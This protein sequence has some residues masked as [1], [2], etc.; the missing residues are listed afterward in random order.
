M[1][2]PIKGRNQLGEVE[3]HERAAR[4][5][6]HILEAAEKRRAKKKREAEAN[7]TQRKDPA[8]ADGNG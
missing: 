4:L 5:F 2:N 6:R 7:G 1:E 8:S 3:D